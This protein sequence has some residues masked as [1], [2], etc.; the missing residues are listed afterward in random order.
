M[1]CGAFVWEPPLEI[2]RSEPLGWEQGDPLS[3]ARDCVDRHLGNR[4][5]CAM[6][7]DHFI[8]DARSLLSAIGGSVWCFALK[9]CAV[10][11][12][13]WCVLVVSFRS[14]VQ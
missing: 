9:C 3:E 4:G 8:S 5:P 14:D 13:V 7:H 12:S 2:V 10:V 11:L 1:G 6:A